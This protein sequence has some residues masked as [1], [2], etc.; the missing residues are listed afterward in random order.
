MF[1]I[2]AIREREEDIRKW[3]RVNVRAKI[4]FT[5][6]EADGNGLLLGTD[7]K[8]KVSGR[9]SEHFFSHIGRTRV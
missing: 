4:V 8:R 3:A 7:G 2:S 9:K 6:L 1:P 5:L